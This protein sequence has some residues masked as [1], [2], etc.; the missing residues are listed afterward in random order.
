MA[1][2]IRI[3]SEF[4]KRG[5]K[6][7]EQQLG[8]LAKT[9]GIALAAVGAAMTAVAVK[10][11]QEFSKFDA[12]LTQS[13]AIMGDLTKTMEED[14]ANAAREVAKATTF[15]AEEAAQSFFYLASAG[16]DAEASVAALPRVAQ[17]A[18]A[19]MFDMSRATD[20]LTDA[21][22]ALGLTIRD[23]AVA[24]MENMIKVSDVLV[25]ANTLSNATVEQFST[26]LTTKAGPALRTLGKDMEEGVAVLAAFADQGIKG[27]EAGTQLSIVLRD[28]STKAIKNKEDF[29]EFGVSVFDANGEMRNLGDIVANL[30]DAL[31][32][33]SDETAKATLLQMGFAD[34]SVQSI[35]AL[36][37]TSDAIKSYE[38]NL[39]SASGFT[40]E[41][42]NKQLDTF[43]SQLKLLES[44]FVDVGIQIGEILTPYLRDLIPVIQELLPVLGDKIAEAIKKVDWEGLI[45]S[46]ADFITL[47][48]DNI[49]NIG[50]LAVGLGIATTALGIYATATLVAITHTKGLTIA[51]LANPWGIA[52]VAVA[53]LTALLI[54][55]NGEVDR[56]TENYRQLSSQIDQTKYSEK[57]LADTY[58]ENAYVASKYGVETDDLRDANLKLAGAADMVSGELGRFNSI[59]MDRLRAEINATKD[60]TESLN[61][62]SRQYGLARM[63]ILT[64]EASGRG[65][66]VKKALESTPFIG[67]TGPSKQ[68][69]AF[70]QAQRLIKDSQKRLADAQKSYNKTIMDAN[71]RYADNVERLQKEFAGRLEGII[72]SSQN[73]LRD[74]YRGAV[75][76]SLTS[77]FDREEEKS[78]EGL[79]KSL[80][81]RL[82][83]SRSLLANSAALASQGFSQTF[84]EQVVSAGVE[85]GNEL[86]SAI[87]ESTPDTQRELQNLFS[88]IET[89]SNQGM[90][91]L[92]ASIYEK[93]GLAT[94][95]LKDL[96]ESTTQEQVDAMIEQAQILDE[97]LVEANDKFIEAVIEIKEALQ[98]QLAEMEDG[99]GGMENTIDQFIGKLDE[100]ILKYKELG[101]VAK[102]QSFD[103]PGAAGEIIKT[104]PMPSS[105][106]TQTPTGGNT[107]V[108]VTVKTDPTESGAMAGK[109]AANVIQRYATRGGAIKGL[110]VAA[111]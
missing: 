46:V 22:S 93:Q 35:L 59:K 32:G 10:S 18:Q 17:F 14:M 45:E 12:A 108:N 27:E 25:R 33:M 13:K 2:K 78:V 101:E 11:V 62:A 39:R 98:E 7:A 36:L 52:A 64:G 88:A 50:K 63:G 56:A 34:R 77:L 72:Q 58:R 106:P 86:A 89:E 51:L 94:T 61:E 26:S 1:I 103:I 41:V 20:L 65:A 19:G 31:E 111:V 81:D 23:D 105:A 30:E 21:Q 85:T 95:Q 74:A 3:V 107:Y 53:G 109:A 9:A 84:I 43:N 76:V 47:I 37:G 104:M 69:Q 71:E 28:L 55:N 83:A 110:K 92:A 73:R 5:L 79:V 48:V 67:S 8:G 6:Q 44:A 16:L 29:A 66:E 4:D 49:D 42:A 75:E 68:Q 87:L 38:T 99:F 70:E 54:A 96:Y 15:S 90:D 57:N 91:A 102:N 60:A 82:T 97:S 80:S 24:N 100:V 40:D